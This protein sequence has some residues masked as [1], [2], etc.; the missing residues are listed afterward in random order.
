MINIAII[1]AGNVAENF[2]LPAWKNIKGIKI[3]GIVDKNLNKAKLLSTKYRVK[4]SYQNI[5]TLFREQKVDAVDIC[6]PNKDHQK[7][8]IYSLKKNKHVICEKPFVLNFKDFRK[9]KYLAKKKKLVCVAAQHQ[10]FRQPSINL[11][12]LVIKNKIGS[13]YTAHISAIFK[14]SKTVKNSNFTNLSKAGGGPLIDLGSHFVDLAWWIMGKPKPISAS[15]YTSNKLAKYL[16]KN[17]KVFWKKFDIEDYASGVVRFEQNKSITFQ[18]SY[19][20][21]CK[22]NEKNIKFFGTKGGLSWPNVELTTIKN[23]ITKNK[24]FFSKEKKS[25]SILELQHFIDSITKKRKQNPDL[26][27]METM[28]KIIETF[29]KSIYKN[30]E[31]II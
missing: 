8:I 29:H 7:T 25:A 19:L 17:E 4:S 27:E 9:I 13:I 26:K 14:R 10:R 2:H 24:S 31:I 15:V 3:V 21:N 5:D 11:K 30:K 22:E 23:N 28:T 16:E 6:T 18:M 20:L 1:G 12:K